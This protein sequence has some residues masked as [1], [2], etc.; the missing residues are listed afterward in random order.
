MAKGA[1]MKE[2]VRVCKSQG[3]FVPEKLDGKGHY[4][5]CTP[6]SWMDHK[7]RIHPPEGEEL[8]IVRIAKT[9]RRDDAVRNDIANLR[10][11]LGVVI[12]GR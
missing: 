4:M 11:K 8:V 1:E 6:G 10:R 9:P 3:Y 2:I 12:R 5:V 7:G